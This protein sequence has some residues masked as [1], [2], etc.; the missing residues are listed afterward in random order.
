MNGQCLLDEPSK[1]NHLVPNIEAII[2]DMK[3]LG[4]GIVE[5][6]KVKTTSLLT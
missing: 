6:I 1:E 2:E 5:H 3:I 4:N